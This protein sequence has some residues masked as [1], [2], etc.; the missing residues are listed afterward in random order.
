MRK[1]YLPSTKRKGVI[2][3]QGVVYGYGRVSSTEQNADRQVLRLRSVGVT[4][5]NI[6][7]DEGSRLY[8]LYK[9]IDDSHFVNFV[10]LSKEL[11]VV[12]KMTEIEFYKSVGLLE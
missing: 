8:S 4:E 9:F 11:G 7:V 1:R 10:F 2:C 12:R 3:L 5:K 6:Y